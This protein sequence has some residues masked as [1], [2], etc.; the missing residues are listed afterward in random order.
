M[1][2]IDDKRSS[3]KQYLLQ[4]L[5]NNISHSPV[6]IASIGKI[7]KEVNRGYPILCAQSKIDSL[8]YSFSSVPLLNQIFEPILSSRAL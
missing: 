8:R 3:L 4:V 1:Y 2:I 6:A 5:N 7:H